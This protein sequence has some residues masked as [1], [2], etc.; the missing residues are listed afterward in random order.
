MATGKGLSSLRRGDWKKTRSPC[1]I[2]AP[3]QL[4]GT[5][6]DDALAVYIY[7]ATR[8]VRAEV[9]VHTFSCRSDHGR[10]LGLGQAQPNDRSVRPCVTVR[11]SELQEL[12]CQPARNVEEDRIFDELVGLSKSAGENSEHV[13][14]HGR[15]RMD[16]LQK[17]VTVQHDRLGWLRGDDG[18]GAGL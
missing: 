16:N 15:A 6:D 8:A 9:F 1:L 3:L 4:F 12:L 18:G 14:C 2:D 13:D 17:I 10:E 5:T 7:D 11:V